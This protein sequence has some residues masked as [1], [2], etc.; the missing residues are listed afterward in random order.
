MKKYV[1]LV[2]ATVF[3]CNVVVSAQEQQK[4]LKKTQNKKE[5]REK[6]RPMPTAQQ[7]TDRMTKELNLTETEKAK[8]LALMQKQEAKQKQHQAEMQKVREAQ[9][10]KFETERKTQ[11]AELK[12]IIGEEKFQQLEKARAQHKEKL[13]QR[14]DRMKGDSAMHKNKRQNVKRKA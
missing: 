2:V 9:K 14:K 8:V 11:D 5:F 4:P 13:M 6:Q 12:K 3:A 1:M 7:R 10:A